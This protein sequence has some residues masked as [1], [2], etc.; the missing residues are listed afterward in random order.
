M[1]VIILSLG[2]TAKGHKP[3]HPMREYC[4]STGASVNLKNFGQSLRNSFRSKK[5]FRKKQSRLGYLPAARS[6]ADGDDFKTPS[7]SVPAT[8]AS[9]SPTSH[10]LSLE[11]RELLEGS[12]NSSLQPRVVVHQAMT[13]PSNSPNLIISTEAAATEDEHQIIARLCREV[14]KAEGKVS[15]D[16]DDD[17]DEGVADEEEEESVATQIRELEAENRRLA[18]QRDELKKRVGEEAEEDSGKE[19]H[20]EQEAKELKQSTARMEAR[21]R[22]LADHNEQLETQLNRLRQ[23]LVTEMNAD[24]Q[25]RDSIDNQVNLPY[26]YGYARRLKVR[27][28][29]FNTASSYPGPE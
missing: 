4:T 16:D 25:G 9:L 28:Y 26:G 19:S 3:E 13:S 11:S 12:F 15:S 29:P 1:I 24:N 18:E 21:M 23:L 7:S 2:K 27:Y 5:Y 10:S 8:A 20:V 6:V 17:E 14:A 22:I